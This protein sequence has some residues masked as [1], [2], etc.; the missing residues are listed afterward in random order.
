[1]SSHPRQRVRAGG[2]QGARRFVASG[3]GNYRVADWNISGGSPAED[4]NQ[5][6]PTLRTASRDLYMGGSGIA[7]GALKRYRTKVVGAGL[8]LRPAPDARLL[9]ISVE[10]AEAWAYLTNK[11]FQLWA[12]GQCDAS[13]QNS[14]GD[15]QQLVMTAWLMSGDVFAL[16]PIVPRAHSSYD[17]RVRVIEADR[18]SNPGSLGYGIGNDVQRLDNGSLVTQGVEVDAQGLVTAYHVCNRHPLSFT[19][20]GNAGAPAWERVPV[21]GAA[22]GRRNILHIMNPERPEQYRGVPLLAPIMAVIKKAGRYIDAEL[23]AAAVA[24][25]VA[26]LIFSDSPHARGAGFDG[27]SEIQSGEIPMTPGMIV[28]MK[29]NGRL[30]TFNPGRPNQAFDAFMQSMIQIIGSAIEIP[31]EVLLMHFTSSYSASRAAL[32]EFWHTCRMMRA[33]LARMFCQPVYEEWLAEDIARGNCQAPGFFEDP[34]L[35]AAWCSAVWTGPAPGHVQPKQE[36]DAATRRMRSGISTG[37]QEAAEFNGSDYGANIVQLGIEERARA[38]NGLPSVFV[39]TAD[40]SAADPTSNEHYT[41]LADA[42]EGDD[43]ML[44]HL[45]SLVTR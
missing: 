44:G 35:R 13:G 42:L 34:L 23:T 10:D 2:A 1:M 39:D 43:E 32:L 4:I 22:T 26:G 21:Y 17:L 45:Q 19:L 36:I 33:W 12:N 29:T 11:R 31:P 27:T 25:N 7:T 30:E 15:L 38:A 24:G 14:L 5:H 37:D 16:L 28:D 3:Y 9:G 41:A 6:L 20:T 40:A 8:T 18:V